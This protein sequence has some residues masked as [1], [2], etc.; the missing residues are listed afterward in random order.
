MTG[1]ARAL[2]PPQRCDACKGGGV[3]QGVCMPLVCTECGGVGWLASPGQDLTT[4]LGRALTRAKQLNRLLE[5]QLPPTDEQGIYRSS[6]R[7]GVRGHYTG[8]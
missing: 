1:F 7:D 6:K 5:A 8:D 4:Q 3:I 2:P